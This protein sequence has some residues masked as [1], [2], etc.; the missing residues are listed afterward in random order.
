MTWRELAR[1]IIQNIPNL[2]MDAKITLITRG[3]L[4]K[5]L[6]KEQI[7]V[8]TLYMEMLGIIVEKSELIEIKD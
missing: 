1:N 7:P 6:K 3:E 5:V 2:D 4:G 8:S